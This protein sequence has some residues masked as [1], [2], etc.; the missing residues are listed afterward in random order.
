MKIWRDHPEECPDCG[1]SAEIFTEESYEDG[2][3][4]Y[5]DDMRCSSCGLKGSWSVYDIDDAY[6]AWDDE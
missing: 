5:G 3:G 1:C 4:N 2:Y 6:A